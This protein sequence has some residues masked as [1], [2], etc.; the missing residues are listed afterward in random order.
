MCGSFEKYKAVRKWRLLVPRPI[1][2][3]KECLPHSVSSFHSI[4][5][6]SD[7]KG[8]SEEQENR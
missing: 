1:V 7:R 2:A 3:Q 6:R 4:N 5:P 8:S